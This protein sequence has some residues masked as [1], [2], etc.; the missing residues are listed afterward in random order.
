MHPYCIILVS[1]LWCTIHCFIICPLQAGLEEYIC[2]SLLN[3]PRAD[4]IYNLKKMEDISSETVENFYQ[5]KRR[6]ISEA[7][8][9][10]S[11]RYHNFKQT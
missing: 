3:H 8:N 10:P 2:G 5:I 4:Y 6:H 7:C 9:L 1:S 11:L